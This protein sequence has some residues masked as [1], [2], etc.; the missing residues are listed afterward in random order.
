MKGKL[1]RRKQSKLEKIHMRMWGG[2]NKRE[3]IYILE[4]SYSYRKDELRRRKSG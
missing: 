2:N 1:K 4:E 3:R